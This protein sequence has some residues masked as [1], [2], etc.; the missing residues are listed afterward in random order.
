MRSIWE[1]PRGR[2]DD[3]I[4]D[5]RAVVDVGTAPRARG[6][7][8]VLGG[9]ERHG[10]NS[11]A[12]AGTTSR[13]PTPS[14]P[15]GEQP[16]GRGDDSLPLGMTVWVQGTAPRARGRPTRAAAGWPLAR[17]SP[18][19][20][21]TTCPVGYRALPVRE[22]PRGRGDD[23][24]GAA[25][26]VP[27]GGTAPRARGRRPGHPRRWVHK[28]NSPAGAGTTASPT[29]PSAW[30]TEQPRGRGDDA[31]SSCCPSTD[32]GTAP[33]ARGRRLPPLHRP[34]ERR[35]SPAGAGT[36]TRTPPTISGNREQPRGRGDDCCPLGRSPPTTGTAPRARGR[37]AQLPR[38]P[39]PA[40][41]S[42]AGAGTTD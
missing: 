32:S 18:A 4:T 22:Q 42:P 11:P 40:R 7:P 12:G 37:L 5:V 3:P 2:G 39:R 25:N 21:G 26:A 19:G 30:S 16:R 17:N 15:R 20:A 35:N 23:I 29:R 6:R 28:R 27:T 8:G 33:R 9:R 31:V 1:Q 41:N 36:T 24:S 10:G 13:S 38:D 14:P 34:A